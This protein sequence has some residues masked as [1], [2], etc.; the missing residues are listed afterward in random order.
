MRFLFVVSIA[1]LAFF[2]LFR[3][4]KTPVLVITKDE[5]IIYT[6]RLE[7]GKFILTFVHSVE[8][9]P[10]YEFYEVLAD[11]TLYLYKTR[12]S[13]MGAGLLFQAEGR[14]EIK[15]G[16]FEAEISRKFKEIFLRVS[17]LD[18]HGI[19]FTDGKVMFK[20]IAQTSDSLKIFCKHSPF[21]KFRFR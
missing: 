17:P 13:S 19:V 5:R 14:F 7:D 6:K 15:D 21:V 4:E 10:V 11:D 9:T 2:I 16:F 12:Y 1:L 20:E 8:K 3:F 18:G